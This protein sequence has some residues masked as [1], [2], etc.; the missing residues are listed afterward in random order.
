MLKM[1]WL[2][3]TV[4]T[5]NSS[6]RYNLIKIRRHNYPSLRLGNGFVK[7]ITEKKSIR[8]RISIINNNKKNVFNPCYKW[9]VNS[10]G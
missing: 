4:K 2:W 1:P 8:I 9:V 7:F 5:I 10:M 6:S 3:N